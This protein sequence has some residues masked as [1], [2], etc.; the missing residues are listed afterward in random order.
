MKLPSNNAAYRRGVLLGLTMA[1][2]MILII[3][4]LLLAFATLVDR[5][6][7]ENL[8]LYRLMDFDNEN[9]KR[10]VRAISTQEPDLA[11]DTVR[12]VERIPKVVSIIKDNELSKE[13][14]A[15]D[16]TIVRAVEQLKHEKKLSATDKKLTTQERLAQALQKQTELEAEI[17]NLANQKSNI[18]SQLKKEGRGV[19]WPPCWAD[20]NG[21]PEYIFQ[22][23]LT[24]HGIIVTDISPAHRQVAKSRL[25]IQS[26]TLGQALATSTF[27]SQTNAIFKWSRQNECHHFVVIDDRTGANEKAIYKQQRTAVESHFYIFQRTSGQASPVTVRAEPTS[28]V[29]PNYIDH[30]L[31]PEAEATPSPKLPEPKKEEPNLLENIESLFQ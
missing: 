2:I 10:I 1:E 21:K 6:K 17:E 19:D 15:L 4:L 31:D 25:P 12:A 9:A 20:K 23:A 8:T 11:E 29:D 13:G 7:K 16:Q 28:E 3:F 24:N 5:Q 27:I 14:E 22:T 30:N 18:M 26:I